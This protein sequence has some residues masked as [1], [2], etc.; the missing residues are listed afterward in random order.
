[1]KEGLTRTQRS[2]LAGWWGQAT[3]CRAR[4]SCDGY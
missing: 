3:N 1:M 2:P 4:R